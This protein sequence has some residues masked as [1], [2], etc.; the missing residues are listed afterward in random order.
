MAD[1]L[2]HPRPSANRHTFAEMWKNEQAIPVPD[3]APDLCIYCCTDPQTDEN[4]PYCSEVCAIDAQQ[5]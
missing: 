1:A 5:N 3:D 2:T 4:A